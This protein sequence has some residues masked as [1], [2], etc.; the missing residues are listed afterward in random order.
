ME[1]TIEATSTGY[2]VAIPI[3]DGLARMLFEE[4]EQ[5]RSHQI[6][7]DV[8]T[9]EEVA[10]QSAAPV[11]ARLNLLSLSARETYRRQL[12]DSFGKGGWS[13]VL[14]RGI[15]L[16]QQIWVERELGISIADARRREREIILFPPYIVD[17]P[18]IL[19]G[20][21]ES[22]KTM[23][24]VALARART[25]PC[26]LW[27]S[28][29]TTVG[30]TLYVDYEADEETLGERC[31]MLGGRPPAFRYWRAGG[32]PLYD[33]LPGLKREVR[34]WGINY[35]IV[36]SAALACGGEPQAPE[37]ALRYFNALA[38]LGIPSLTIAHVT[39]DQRNLDFPFGSVFWQT[40]ARSTI[41]CQMELDEDDTIS[42]IGLFH[43][44]SNNSRRAPPMQLRLSINGSIPQARFE[45]EELGWQFAER[46]PAHMQ[47]RRY[48]T[49]VGRAQKAEIVEETGL[50]DA[51]VKKAL[52]RMPDVMYEGESRSRD[53][54]W[55][56]VSGRTMP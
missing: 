13:N 44:K 52:G 43:K 40:T 41:F 34:R 46:L 17:G 28:V 25:E 56:L 19:Y 1:A 47:I 22:G 16:V 3:A 2:L 23:L 48:L 24:A 9:W 55:V 37:A 15:A 30:P 36:D 50:S 45:R 18:T 26:E 31:D 6:E 5:T 32:I 35:V 20:Q 53:G 54:Y 4:L 33:M 29:W 10:G 42:H 11:T 14:S 8:S 7:A 39:K 27:E 49:S 51:S 38:A 12:D 21:G